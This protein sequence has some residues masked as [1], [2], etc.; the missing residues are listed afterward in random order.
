[1][2]A[3]LEG[4]RSCKISFEPRLIRLVAMLSIYS[5]LVAIS[6]QAAGQI[7]FSELPVL[8]SPGAPGACSTGVE[9]S[10][11]TDAGLGVAGASAFMRQYR[12]P[13][14]RAARE[15]V[16][17]RNPSPAVTLVIA[18]DGLGS[19]SLIDGGQILTNWHV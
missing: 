19:G 6:N 8:P 7:G 18:Q 11:S 9:L 17:F 12:V 10:T 3:A 15:A 4:T 14:I 1:M 2:R 5:A 13:K 16:L